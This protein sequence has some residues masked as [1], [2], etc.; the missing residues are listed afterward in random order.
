MRRAL[1][2]LLI[3]ASCTPCYA[4]KVAIAPRTEPVAQYDT[5]KVTATAYD[6]LG[7]RS[8]SSSIHWSA[9]SIVKVLPDSATKGQTA[10]VVGLAQG[11]TTIRATWKHS[12][13]AI[14]RDSV[15]QRVTSPR[16]IAV[17]PFTLTPGLLY[18]MDTSARGCVYVLARD[19]SG[20]LL[21]GRRITSI[22]TNPF[23]ALPRQS[24][25]PDTSVNPALVGRR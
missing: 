17:Q 20:A 19:R 8:P 21:T 5:L 14:Y 24:A 4:Q 11:L 3:A 1:A 13:G 7:R 25:C 18:R 10:R 12:S 9:G 2:A 15:D 22:E 6:A 23:T 16:V